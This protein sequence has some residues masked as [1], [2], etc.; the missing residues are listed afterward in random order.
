MYD[1]VFLHRGFRYVNSELTEFSHDTWSTPADV[2]AVK[3]L[4]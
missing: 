3:L 1:T 4:D 2:G